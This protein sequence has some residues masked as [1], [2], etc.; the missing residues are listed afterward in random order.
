MVYSAFSFRGVTTLIVYVDSIILIEND[1][2]RM[3]ALKGCLIA[4]FEIKELGK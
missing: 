3:G 4:K 2:A 1:Q